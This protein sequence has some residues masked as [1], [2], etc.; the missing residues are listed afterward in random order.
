MIA[1]VGLEPNC[2]RADYI[3]SI[4]NE[5]KSDL[6]T[7]NPIDCTGKGLWCKMAIE[8]GVIGTNRT[9]PRLHH[10]RGAWNHHQAGE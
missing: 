3:F 6:M 1:P 5:N 2:Q 10:L 9:N 4:N 7:K 8:K